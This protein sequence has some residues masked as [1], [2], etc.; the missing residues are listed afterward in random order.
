MLNNL[1]AVPDNEFRKQA[2]SLFTSK[3]DTPET[4]V[5][6][7]KRVYDILR[8]FEA[9]DIITRKNK[10]IYFNTKP[11]LP[12][13]TQSAAKIQEDRINDKK[14]MLLMK[15]NM[16]LM[17][18]T[19]VAMNTRKNISKESAILFPFIVFA[20]PES[21]GRYQ[22]SFDK[23]SLD[24]WF[25]HYKFYSLIEILQNIGLD[26]QLFKDICEKSKYAS[27]LQSFKLVSEKH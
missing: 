2:I 11:V 6:I 21:N 26:Q 22:L 12:Q 3:D 9:A 10:I 14:R 25:D 4:L 15:V 8:V 24:M 1:K 19:L 18:K 17:S 16:L 23:R 20:I 5:T 7:K 13:I 27:F